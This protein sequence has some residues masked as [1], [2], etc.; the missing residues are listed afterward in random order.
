MFLLSIEEPVYS[1]WRFRNSRFLTI[2]PSMQSTPQTTVIGITPFGH[3]STIAFKA[4]MA[5]CPEITICVGSHLLW[6]THTAYW[7]AVAC[8]FIRGISDVDTRTADF[9]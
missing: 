8:S 7:C 5:P 6:P 9:G 2:L 1:S 4:S 3:T